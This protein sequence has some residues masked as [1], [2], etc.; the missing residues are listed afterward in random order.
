[1]NQ[2]LSSCLSGRVDQLLAGGFVHIGVW[3][4]Y[5]GGRMAFQGANPVP[6][7]PGVY[8]YAVGQEVLYVGSAQR[9]LRRRI[10]HYASSKNLPTASRIREKVLETLSSVTS[11]DIYVIVLE[12]PLTLHGILPVDPVA[13]LEEGL[14]RAIKPKWNRRGRGAR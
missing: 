12:K 9:G 11:V 1:M 4:P 2:A 10:R 7:E 3:L 13:G 5:E 14:I 6:D 8:A